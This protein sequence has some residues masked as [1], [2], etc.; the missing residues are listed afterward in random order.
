MSAE[1]LE[2]EEIFVTH[3]KKSKFAKTKPMK[4][5]Y[6][7]K[8]LISESNNIENQNQAILSKLENNFK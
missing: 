7:H 1:Y 4:L 5:L 3:A 2:S 8:D 6:R